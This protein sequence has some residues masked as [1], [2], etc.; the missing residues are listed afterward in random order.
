MRYLVFHTF[1]PLKHFNV[2]IFKTYWQQSKHCGYIIY[3]WTSTQGLAHKVHEYRCVADRLLAS[4]LS[5]VTNILREFV[6]IWKKKK[7]TA[8]HHPFPDTLNWTI[9]HSLILKWTIGYWDD[10]HPILHI[11]IKKMSLSE[12]TMEEQRPQKEF[13]EHKLNL[14][15]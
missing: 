15:K 13:K 12:S 9:T 2:N 8:T 14:P 11:A 3:P 1:S 6:K 10:G 4:N 5:W 7:T